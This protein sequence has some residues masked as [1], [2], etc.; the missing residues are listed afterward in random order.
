MEAAEW[1]MGHGGGGVGAMEE[2]SPSS[3]PLHLSLSI[4]RTRVGVTWPCLRQQR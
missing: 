3:L 4:A 2:V 1:E